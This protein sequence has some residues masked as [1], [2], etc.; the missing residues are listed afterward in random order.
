MIFLNTE[1]S[2]HIL[3]N[4]S[5]FE[6]LHPNHHTKVATG[7]GKSTLT[8]Q[9][10]GLEKIFD[11]LGNLWL[12]PNS[13]YIPDLTTSLLALFSIAKSKTQIRRTAS[14]FEIYLDSNNEPSFI[15]PIMS[16]ILETYVELSNSRCLNTQV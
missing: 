16:G 12:L 15:C 9:G 5:F 10:K 1:A 8:L 6:N 14:H 3:S 2:N 11:R 7:C 4:K 13:L